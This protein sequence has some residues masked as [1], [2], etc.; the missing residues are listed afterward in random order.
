MNPVKIHRHDIGGSSF[1][2]DA[3]DWLEHLRPVPASKPRPY[4]R[5]T[6]FT[7]RAV[8]LGMVNFILCVGLVLL[9]TMIFYRILVM[10]LLTIVIEH[11]RATQVSW[12]RIKEKK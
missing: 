4:A 5:G 10:I 3:M 1:V 8:I 12:E 6:V 2:E 11:R 7:K 9:V